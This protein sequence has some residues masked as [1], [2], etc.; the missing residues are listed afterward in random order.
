MMEQNFGFCVARVT[1][2]RQKREEV[3]PDSLPMSFLEF[4]AQ[5]TSK[6][7]ERVIGQ[8][9]S[10]RFTPSPKRLERI[11]AYGPVGEHVDGLLQ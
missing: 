6:P 9:S 11:A 10:E 5:E 2:W 7:L 8:S 4:R 3:Q 1:A